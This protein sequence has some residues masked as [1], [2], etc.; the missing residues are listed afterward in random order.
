M[1]EDIQEVAPETEATEVEQETETP[2]TEAEAEAPEAEDAPPKQEAEKEQPDEGNAPKSRHQRRKEQMD[3]LRNENDELSEK[4]KAT[5]ERLKRIEEAAQGAA[6]PK[7]DDFETYEEFQ[8][9]LSA[10]HAMRMMDDRQRK[11]VEREMEAQQREIERVQRQQHEEIAQN[12]AAQAADAKTRYA[13]FEQVAFSAPISDQ[14][15]QMVASMDAG[16]DV[17]YHL[18][19]NPAEAARISRLPPVEAAMELGRIEARVNAPK[20]KTVTQAPDPVSTVRSNGAIDKDPDKMTPEE[21][22]R[23]R[24]SGGTFKIGA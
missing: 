16:A 19:L 24:E 3:R 10:H 8:A 4:L 22:D 13:D 21:Y 1:T 14:V 18:G 2:V 23:W 20:P 15:A 5:R 7:Q 12:W 9:A 11:D 6:P 17:A